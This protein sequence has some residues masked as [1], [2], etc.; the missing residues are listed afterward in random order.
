MFVVDLAARGP[1]EFAHGWMFIGFFFNVLL[2]GMM[3]NQVYIYYSSY[4]RTDKPW[5]KIFVAGLYVAVIANTCFIFAYLYRSVITF[6]G[7]VENLG[8]SNWLFA[9]EP[10]TTGV[11]AMAVQSFFAWRVYALT[12]SIIATAI[13]GALALAT[14][15]SAII[16]GWEV[17]RRATFVEFA[18]FKHTVILWLVASVVCDVGITA[19]LVVYLHKTGF[20]RS[21]RMI[22]QIIR[23]TMQTGLLTMIVATADLIVYLVDP[24]GTHLMINY[25]LAGL[26]SNSLMSSLNSRKGWKYDDSEHTES[27][28]IGGNT[29][30]T[31]QRNLQIASMKPNDI[32]DARTHPEVYVH[33]ESHELR[34][35]GSTNKVGFPD[36]KTRTLGSESDKWSN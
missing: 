22:N 11:I 35:V 13:L 15:V 33:V 21:D 4:Y 9:S 24:S 27:E 7:D 31:K 34:D 26:Y 28:A 17:G 10:A 14:G 1:A 3:T 30:L 29:T 19:I 20:R 5:I 2:L 18:A 16:T 36:D 6:F 25:S 8:R 23:V 32:I 12:S